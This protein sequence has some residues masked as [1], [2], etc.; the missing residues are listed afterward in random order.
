MRIALAS[1]SGLPEWEI[2]DR[3]LHAALAARGIE[4]AVVPW[5]DA[6]ADWAGFD[7]CLIRTTWD[8]AERREEFLAWAE[9][10]AR[11]TRLLHPPE[12]VRW[13]THKRYL[14]ELEA[15]GAP[16]IPT[17]YF[18]RGAAPDL[19]AVLDARGWKQAFLKPLV[20]ATARETLRFD[21]SPEGLA[22]AEAQ[23]GRLLAVEEMMLQPYLA[24]VESQGELSAVFLG[25]AFSH[26]VRKIPSP[27]DYRVQ[28]DFG[29]RDEPF[30]LTA[31]EVGLA[32]RVLELARR[33]VGVAELLY[34]RVDF[35][36]D[37]AGALRLNELELVEPSLFFRHAPE[38]GER[39]A[40]AL[41]AALRPRS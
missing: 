16:V 25:G 9:R 23:L 39:L 40:A 18:E 6:A 37:E 19:S 13:N 14:A 27:G 15:D 38:A 35:L 20:G 10:A 17:V 32:A 7:A 21:T 1:C 26:A 24:S 36:R 28:D 2:D 8:Y 12:V 30:E 22:R 4:F 5:D 34:A 31:E 33:R 3:P 41:C 29:A 11:K